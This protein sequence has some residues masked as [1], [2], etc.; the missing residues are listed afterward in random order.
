M[1]QPKNHTDYKLECRLEIKYGYVGTFEVEGLSREEK[2]I[3]QKDK[4][5]NDF[6]K[7]KF[8]DWEY[9][10]VACLIEDDKPNKL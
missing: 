1:W 3:W 5:T 6:I 4:E 10:Q 2:I 9:V 7:S 8:P